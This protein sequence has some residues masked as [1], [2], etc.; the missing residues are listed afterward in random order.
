[1]ETYKVRDAM[2][3]ESW[4]EREMTE[5]PRKLHPDMEGMFNY[6]GIK[7]LLNAVAEEQSNG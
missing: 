2:G 7:Q 3:R 1:M 4:V 6:V 5:E